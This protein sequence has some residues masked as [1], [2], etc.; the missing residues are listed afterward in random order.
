[1]VNRSD[2]SH[3][4]SEKTITG[5]NIDYGEIGLTQEEDEKVRRKLNCVIIAILILLFIVL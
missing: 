5:Q 2:G 4:S 1:M 3:S